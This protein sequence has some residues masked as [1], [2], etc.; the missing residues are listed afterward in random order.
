MKPKSPVSA[1]ALS[2]CMIILLAVTSRITSDTKQTEQPVTTN[3]QNTQTTEATEQ[4]G[5]ALTPAQVANTK[6]E[7]ALTLVQ[8]ATTKS[9]QAL[10]VDDMEIIPITVETTLYEEV[11]NT[12]E[13]INVEA[14]RVKQ[15]GLGTTKNETDFN[16]MT[17]TANDDLF[18]TA[19][20]ST[21]FNRDENINRTALNKTEFTADKGLFNATFNEINRLKVLRDLTGSGENIF[22]TLGNSMQNRTMVAGISGIS[23]TYIAEADKQED[24]GEIFLLNKERA[25]ASELQYNYNEEM[26]RSVTAED[27]DILCRIVEAEAT[28]EKTVG[29]ILV[30]NVILNRVNSKSFPGSIEGVVFQKIGDSYQFSP[31]KDGRY[32]TVEITDS[33]IEAVERALS[34]EDYSQGALF[35]FER[36]RTTAKKAAWFDSLKF[37]LKYGCH[38]FFR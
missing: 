24:E 12:E 9:G 13:L 2:V 35:F 30:A 38:E 1:I 8:V 3:I 25:E 14:E 36:A 26:A 21:L 18:N 33:T 5:Q 37:I 22:E 31:T 16:L 29:K 17:F 4:T 23:L 32:W 20:N 34:G 10:T 19:T 27:F 7:Q 28:G 11:A 6:P 15:D